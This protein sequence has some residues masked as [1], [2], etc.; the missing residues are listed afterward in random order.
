M[1]THVAP[2]PPISYMFFILLMT[3]P[4]LFT[5]LK[6]PSNFKE[7]RI[8]YYEIGTT[9]CKILYEFSLEFLFVLEKSK[10]II[11]IRFKV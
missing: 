7:Q 8:S 4:V 10:T 11:A 2:Q 5:N 1:F 9:P 6:E 3:L